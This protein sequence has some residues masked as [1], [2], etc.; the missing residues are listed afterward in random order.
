M[1]VYQFLESK[2]AICN[3]L[4]SRLKVSEIDKLNDPFEFSAFRM[5]SKDLEDAQRSEKQKISE[6]FKLLCFSEIYSDPAMWAYY[7]DNHKGIC[8]GF[9]VSINSLIPVNYKLERLHFPHLE[10]LSFEDWHKQ[11]VIPFV[12]TKSESWKHEKEFRMLITTNDCTHE[13]DKFYYPFDINL[14][15]EE[16][17][18]GHR[19][20]AEAGFEAPKLPPYAKLFRADL[21]TS[22]FAI[23]RVEINQWPTS[24]A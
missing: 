3:L 11:I 9:E 7:G 10:Q 1:R 21:S 8:L 14:K 18:L 23:E 12:S 4:H 5:P 15:L 13:N 19:F 2:W 6:F 24:D 17:I 16:V 22:N 20:I